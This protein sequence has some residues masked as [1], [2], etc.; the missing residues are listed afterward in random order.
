MNTDSAI[1]RLRRDLVLGTLLKALLFAAAMGAVF[2]LPV[3]A[4]Q[5]SSGAALLAIAIIWLILG[6]NSAKGA[7]ISAETPNLIAVGQLK[8]AEEQIDEAL[9]RFSLFRAVKLQAAHQLAM[10][11]HAQRRYR[12]ATAICR[13]ILSHRTAAAAPMS[14]NV[15]LLMADSTLELDDVHGAYEAMSG[16]YGQKLSLPQVLDLLAAQLDYES[17]IGAWDRVMNQPMAKVQL[18]ELM[19]TMP[20]ARTQALLALGARHVGRH[21]FAE[22]LLA[23]IE[24]LIDPTRLVAERP[25]LAQLWV[26][27]PATNGAAAEPAAPAVQTSPPETPT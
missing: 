15:R 18:A 23:R 4:P 10:L 24:L 16:L 1:S 3:A 27:R 20:A 26:P 17:R 6:Y 19:P 25:L 21:D 9:R 2:V 7:R 8:E 22:W 13:E 5:I 14:R 12:E 11:R